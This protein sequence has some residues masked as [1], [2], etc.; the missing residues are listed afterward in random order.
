MKPSILLVAACCVALGG[1]STAG[2]GTFSLA[3]NTNVKLGMALAAAAAVYL[4]YDPLAPNWEIEEA[5]LADDSY[6]LS[7]KMKRFHTG[8]SGEALQVLKRRA[9]QLQEKNGFA[10]YQI[11]SYSEGIESQTPIA[12]RVAEG[13]IRLVKGET[14]DSFALNGAY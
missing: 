12:Q 7:M 4:I 10:A 2:T 1:C 8:G 14:A 5:K 9:Q 6:R 11:A 13:T 3:A